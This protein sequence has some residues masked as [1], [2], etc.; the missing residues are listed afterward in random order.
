MT[1]GERKVRGKFLTADTL[2]ARLAKRSTSEFGRNWS[3]RRF[4]MDAND[5]TAKGCCNSG[6]GMKE[7]MMSQTGSGGP[8]AMMQKMM[9]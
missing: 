5:K 9:E 7:K 8:M 4:N 3:N 2:V 6:M 1:E